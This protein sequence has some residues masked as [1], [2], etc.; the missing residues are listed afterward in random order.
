MHKKGLKRTAFFTLTNDGFS[1]H[2]FELSRQYTQRSWN[3]IKDRLYRE[4]E[5]RAPGEQAWIYAVSKKRDRYLC[6]R[7]ARYGVRIELEHN[8]NTAGPETFFIRMT[9]NPRK[10]LDPQSSYLGILSP[11]KDAA[12]TIAKAFRKLL[13]NT[14]FDNELDEFYLTRV[15]LCANIQCNNGKIFREVIRA[16]QKLP[17]PPKMQR[18]YYQNPDPKKERRY[19]KHY[20]NYTCGSFDLVL[21]D[22]TFQISEGGLR[23]SYEKLPEGVLR[24]ELRLR[25]DW[26][27]SNQ[28]MVG[29]ESTVVYLQHLITKAKPFLLYILTKSIPPAKYLRLPELL[30]SIWWSPYPEHIRCRMQKLVT[31]THK[32][33]SVDAAFEKMRVSKEER[34]DLLLRFQR[35]GISPIPLR[36]NFSAEELPNPTR[37]FLLLDKTDGPVSV[38]YIRCK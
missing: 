17:A 34:K 12:E 29:Q 5:Q 25:R 11:T 30:E 9:I 4:L 8:I 3:A 24:C 19:N 16:S 38:E 33:D 27:R 6:T 1:I 22:K 10:L 31:L 18:H 14:P 26:I 13:K 35:L 21:Y 15:D 20:V 32:A 36:K 23:L 7:Y 37:L 2:T 28:K